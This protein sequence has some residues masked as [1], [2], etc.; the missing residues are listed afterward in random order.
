MGG[1]LRRPNEEKKGMGHRF[2]DQTNWDIDS[3]I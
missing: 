2:G 3:A 1:N